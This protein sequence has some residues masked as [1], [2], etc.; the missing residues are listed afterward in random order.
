M[1][2]FVQ[3]SIVTGVLMVGAAAMI[4]ARRYKNE[5]SEAGCGIA[6]W[7]IFIILCMWI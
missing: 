5:D 1:E 7:T 4:L 2:T 3:R 6:G